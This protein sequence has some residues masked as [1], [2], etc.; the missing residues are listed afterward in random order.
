MRRGFILLT[1]TLLLSAA[2]LLAQNDVS[3]GA[4]SDPIWVRYWAQPKVILFGPDQEDFYR[5]MQSIMFPWDNHEDPSNPEAIDA[6]VQYLQA[7]PN[8]K[9]YI[10]GYASSKGVWDYNLHLSQRRANWVKQHLISKGI[11][12]DRI[13]FAVGWG[14]L[15]PVCAELN[16]DCW[17][18]NRLVRFEYSAN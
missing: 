10:D 6:N 14:Q 7:H 13:V 9:F 4:P 2:Q 5:N 15:Y 8:V 3:V 16:D 11:S 1:A 17:T 12:E 18:K